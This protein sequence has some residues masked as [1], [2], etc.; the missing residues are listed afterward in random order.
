MNG[1]EFSSQ[2]DIYANNIASNQAPGWTEEEKSVFLT[3][4]QEQLCLSLYSGRNTYGSSFDATEELK[5]ALA[6]IIKEEM[7]T[8]RIVN[9]VPISTN[10]TFFKLPDDLWFITYE[11]AMIPNDKCGNTT[12]DV[13]PTK[14]DEYNR[15]KTNPFRGANDRRALRLDGGDG[16]VEII[17]KSDYTILK[18]FIKYLR[19]PYPIILEEF[20]DFTI[21]GHN[22]PFSDTEV[23]EL[24]SSLHQVILENAVKMALEVW[25]TKQ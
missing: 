22:T 24:D 7:L 15:L 21:N 23:C 25:T 1:P 8:P 2:F 6:N 11:A 13:V 4:S 18:Y 14:Q 5:R 10:S 17:P 20:S 16:L 12:I 3:K 9:L 19:K